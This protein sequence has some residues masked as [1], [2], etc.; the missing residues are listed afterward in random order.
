[1]AYH[2]WPDCLPL[3]QIT[4]YTVSMGDANNVRGG[5]SFGPATSRNRFTRQTAILSVV[6]VM[7]ELQFGIFEAW[8]KHIIN[9]GSAWF[10]HKQNIE[11]LQDNTCRF[12]GGYQASLQTA[13]SWSVSATVTVDEP[14]RSA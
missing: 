4:G 13:G 3:P 10:T 6:Y 5:G 8:W 2:A 11:G 14:Y 9:D 12:S 1:M 7:S